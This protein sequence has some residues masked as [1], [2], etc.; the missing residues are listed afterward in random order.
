[1]R[2]NEWKTWGSCGIVTLFDFKL[3]EDVSPS[4]QTKMKSNLL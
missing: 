3:G 1:L 2:E 4:F